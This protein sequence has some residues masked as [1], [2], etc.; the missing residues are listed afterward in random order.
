MG[1]ETTH[2]ADRVWLA[3]GSEPDVTSH[4]LTETLCVAHPI[5][6]AAGWPVL[7]EALRW[8]GTDVHLLGR[9]AML[10]LGPAAGNLWG[11]RLGAQIIADHITATARASDRRAR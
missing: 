11:A 2:R 6:C 7:D 5:P 1:D 9:P 10:A 4:R 8:P 3:T